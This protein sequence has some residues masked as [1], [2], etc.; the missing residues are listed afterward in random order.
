MRNEV[1]LVISVCRKHCNLKQDYMAYKLGVSVSTYANIE[2]GRVDINT[3]KLFEVA[4]LLGIK[5]H[6]IIALA[7]EIL[8]IG[9][10]G[11]MPSV[12]KRM[13]RVN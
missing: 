4:L 2:K 13:L 6:Q 7:E 11:W 5:A 9:E 1:G 10:H 12:A 8:E 3:G